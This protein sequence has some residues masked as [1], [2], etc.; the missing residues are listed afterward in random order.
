MNDLVN[1]LRAQLDDDEQVAR[2]A[3]S[4]PW[5][6]HIAPDPSGPD[7]TLLMASRVISA[8]HAADDLLWPADAEH[9]ARH[10]PARVLAEVDAKRQLLD[11]IMNLKRPTY[12]RGSSIVNGRRGTHYPA[13]PVGPDP[14]DALL[15]L[16]ALPYANRPGYRDE[17]RP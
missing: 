10:D 15:R 13:R 5:I 14:R 11:G 3:I 7:H 16:L 1:F 6:H 9:I 4:P 12:Q 2:A 17:W 8:G